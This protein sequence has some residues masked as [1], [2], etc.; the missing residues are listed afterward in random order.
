MSRFRFAAAVGAPVLLAL[1]ACVDDIPE[2][3]GGRDVATPGAEAPR[4]VEFYG[5]DLT[6]IG[7]DRGDPGAPIV[8]VD[9]SD[10]GCPYCG[11]HATETQPALEA[12]FVRTG[13]VFYKYVPFVMGM[14]PNGD[15]SA[16]AAECGA[17]QGRFW[18][19][20]DLLYRNQREWKRTRAPDSLFAVYARQAGL[21]QP[22]FT[23]CYAQDRGA[24]RTRR[25]NLAAQALG[26]RATPTF[27]VNGRP[28]EGALPLER[29]QEV[30]RAMEALRQ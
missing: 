8:L 21:D 27:F 28:V 17:E 20:H 30:F 6:G 1:S 3:V 24:M 18:E 29:F 13:K 16:R 23:A 14:F 22:R 19:V 26:I 15:L 11:K 7:Y 9:F 25:A 12:E 5:V 4:R 10:F 2:Y